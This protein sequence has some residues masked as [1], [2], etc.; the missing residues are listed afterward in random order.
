MVSS[1]ELA[2]LLTAEESFNEMTAK[3][4]G[5]CRLLTLLARQN[6]R[7]AGPYIG[8]TPCCLSTSL[9]LEIPAW[10]AAFTG[11]LK[12]QS[13]PTRQMRSGCRVPSRPI[14]GSG[15]VPQSC[16]SVSSVPPWP[17][18]R[19][20]RLR[21]SPL[22]L[23]LPEDAQQISGLAAGKCVWCHP[24]PFWPP[25]SCPPPPRVRAAAPTQVSWAHSKP[26]A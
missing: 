10:E 18:P 14:F 4:K 7:L 20:P 3:A 15:I 1:S 5:S 17:R 9:A 8:P 12:P 16:F 25:L 6:R 2:S 11:G 21:P 22:P 23:F 24:L 19:S 13:A 26:P